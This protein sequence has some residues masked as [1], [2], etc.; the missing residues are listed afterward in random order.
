M[1]ARAGSAAAGRSSTTRASRSASTSRSSPTRTASSST[2]SVGVS[3]VLFYDPVERV[4]ATLHPNHTWEKVVFDPWRQ[5]TWDVNDT[6]LRNARPATR[7]PTPTSAASS[8]SL[9]DAADY[10]A[11]LARAAQ[12]RR[13]RPSERARRRHSAP[14]RT[15]T[16]RPSPTPTRSAAPS[17]PSP[18]TGSSQRTATTSTAVEEFY[19][20]PRRARHR[21]QPARGASTP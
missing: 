21:R 14:M 19:R 17:S 4:V 13:A 1:S 11:D 10:L 2:C 5:E 18:T 16:R 20:H 3:P 7:G 9:P 15:P 6:V 12:R 8:P